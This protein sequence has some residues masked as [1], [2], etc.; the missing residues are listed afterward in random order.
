MAEYNSAHTGPE[1]DAAVSAVKTKQSTW[2]NK[3]DKITG[4][5]GQVVGF[6][7]SGNPIA[8]EAP[9]GGASSWNDLADKPFG[10]VYGDTLTFDGNTDEVVNV[11]GVFFKVSDAVP[12]YADIVKGGHIIMGGETFEFTAEDVPESEIVDPSG[13]V[14]IGSA[15]IIVPP[16]AVGVMIEDL[17][18]AF[19][20]SGT[21]F[22]YSEAMGALVTGLQLNGYT[23]FATVKKI[24]QKYI[25]SSIRKLY[26]STTKND[27]FLYT[28]ESCTIK[29]TVADVPDT[30]QFMIGLCSGAAASAWL[31]PLSVYSRLMRNAA[32]FCEV[33]VAYGVNFFALVTAEYSGS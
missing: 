19:Q 14:A 21:Y 10:E 29:A 2:D 25:P 33:T 4:K 1:I 32:G 28:D 24:E 12:T 16:E 5:A 15:V 13:I 17:G 22:V 30:T 27:K 31:S 20:E 6:D 8:Q 7:A 23:E 18:F 11:E 26:F 9:S 3:Q